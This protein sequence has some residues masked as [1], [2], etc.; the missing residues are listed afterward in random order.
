MLERIYIVTLSLLVTHQI[1]AAYWKEW[2]MFL[3]PGGIQFFD[4][5]N[6]AIIPV[7]LVGFKSVVLKKKSGYYYS[8]FLS[9]LGLLTFVI[10]SGFYLNGYSQFTLPL[11]LAVIILCAVSAVLQLVMTVRQREV[12]QL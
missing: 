12:F 8:C 2:E 6:L 10:H 3:I 4:I 1:D 5:F 9:S 7:L 11:S